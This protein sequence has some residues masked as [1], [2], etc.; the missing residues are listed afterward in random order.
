MTLILYQ[1]YCYFSLSN[2]LRENMYDYYP[3]FYVFVLL[4]WVTNPFNVL[5]SN[6][7]VNDSFDSCPESTYD[8]SFFTNFCISLNKS[9]DFLIIKINR[10]FHECAIP[11]TYQPCNGWTILFMSINL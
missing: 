5:N 8:S 7:N 10:F 2:L 1:W 4:N 11:F 3:Y 9:T 6:S